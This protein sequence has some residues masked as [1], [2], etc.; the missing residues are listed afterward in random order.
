ML[1]MRHTRTALVFLLL[2]APL[3]LAQ[4]PPEGAPSTPASSFP[5]PQEPGQRNPAA[6]A[7]AEQQRKKPKRLFYVIPLYN[8]TFEKNPAPLTTADKFRIFGRDVTDPYTIV[9]VAAQAG[10]DQATDHFSEYGQGAAGYGKRFGQNYGDVAIGRFLAVAVF[11]SLLHEDPRYFRQGDGGFDR[12]LRHAIAN[13][14]VTRTDS[15]ERTFNWARVLGRFTAGSITLSYFPT[16]QRTAPKYFSGVGYSLGSDVVQN[17]FNEFGPDVERW[18][19]RGLV[20]DSGGG[21][22]PH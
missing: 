2:I 21:P 22:A 10:L 19:L 11:P 15:Q 20:H 1:R 5:D 3:S 4:T 13:T 12:R 8:V 7:K 9:S 16:A 14:F 18:I 6:T 17:I